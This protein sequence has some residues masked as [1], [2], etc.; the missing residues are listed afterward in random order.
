M[1]HVKS[2]LKHFPLINKIYDQFNPFAGLILML[3]RVVEVRSPIID[4]RKL[5]ITPAFLEQTIEQYQAAGYQFVSI[6]QAYQIQIHR[7][8]AQKPYLCFTFDDGFRDNLTMALP[9][10]QKYHI[11]FT[12]YVTTDFPDNRAFVWWYWLENLLLNESTFIVNDG[13]SYPCDSISDRNQTFE[14]IKQK[15]RNHPSANA[16]TALQELLG[17]TFNEYQ[18]MAM[19]DLLL[20]WDDIRTLLRSGL[21]TIGSHG[22]THTSLTQLNESSLM[23]ELQQSRQRLKKETGQEPTHF[24]YPYGDMNN[25]VA[26]AVKQSG[27]L[28]AVCIDGGMQRQHQNPFYFKRA[29]L[30]QP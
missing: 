16:K 17:S 13:D 15:M 24:A 28:S 19:P 6:D 26:A 12:V 3:H 2:L 29:L 25:Y 18:N 4:N 30:Y 14:A 22:V 9:V 8:K 27:Y 20:S 23:N 11:P 10:F 7:N 5:E 1:S 21:C